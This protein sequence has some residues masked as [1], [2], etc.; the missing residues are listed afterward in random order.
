MGLEGTYCEVNILILKNPKSLIH[1]LHS[2]LSHLSFWR[3]IK[4][5]E[6]RRSYKTRRCKASYI[7]PHRVSH[8]YLAST[9]PFLSSCT[10]YPLPPIPAGFLRE[11]TADSGHGWIGG[12]GEGIAIPFLFLPPLTPPTHPSYS[13]ESVPLAAD[14]SP[15]LK[16]REW[17]P[18]WGITLLP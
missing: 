15:W 2:I 8:P 14:F 17:L 6:G 1:S 5:E 11:T 3:E 7:P 12:L 9:P 13:L 18:R 4:R 16:A 10:P